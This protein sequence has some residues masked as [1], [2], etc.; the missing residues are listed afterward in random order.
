MKFDLNLALSYYTPQ[1]IAKYL[2]DVA[3]FDYDAAKA[4][5]YTDDEIARY[6]SET[7]QIEAKEAQPVPDILDKAKE[8]IKEAVSPL[9]QEPLWKQVLQAPKAAAETVLG[10]VTGMLAMLPAQVTYAAGKALE[11]LHQIFPE[12]KF[13]SAYTPGTAEQSKQQV[14]EALTYHPTTPAAQAALNLA[15]LPTEAMVEGA[16][17]V[18]GPI[19]RDV[20]ETTLSALPYK[21]VARMLPKTPSEAL[22][23]STKAEAVAEFTPI[24]RTIAEEGLPVSPSLIRPS[25]IT[26]LVEGILKQAPITRDIISRYQGKV[27]AWIDDNLREVS[28]QVLSPD[29]VQAMEGMI[30]EQYKEA[31]NMIQA[32]KIDLSSVVQALEK[33]DEQKALNKNG[34]AL[35]AELKLEPEVSLEK[36]DQLK[37]QFSVLKTDIRRAINNRF[38][39]ALEDYPGGTEAV[40][41]LRELDKGYRYQI[42]SRKIQKLIENSYDYEGRFLPDRFLSNYEAIKSQIKNQLPNIKETLD[43]VAEVAK[44]ARSDIEAWRQFEKQGGDLRALLKLGGAVAVISK[45]ELAM[46]LAGAALVARSMMHPKGVVRRLVGGR[47]PKTPAEAV[48]IFAPSPEEPPMEGILVDPEVFTQFRDQTRWP[49]YLTLYSPEELRQ[50]GAKTYIYGGKLL[51]GY[52]IMPD[53][54]LVNVFN[55]TKIPG[56]GQALI[57][58]AIKNGATKLDCIGDYLR[59]KYEAAGFEVYR[60]EPW[61][62]R[63]APEGWNYE[64]NGRPPIYY[65]RLKQKGGEAHEQGSRTATHQSAEGGMVE[66]GRM[67][68]AFGQERS[69]RPGMAR[70]SGSAE[71]SNYLASESKGQ[72]LGQEQSQHSSSGVGSGDNP[73]EKLPFEGLTPGTYEWMKVWRQ[74]KDNPEMQQKMLEYAKRLRG[75]A[76][77]VAVYLA[78]DQDEQEEAF[79]LFAG[80]LGGV[81]AVKAPKSKLVEAQELELKGLPKEGIWQRTGWIK[82]PENKWRFEIDDKSARILLN[83]DKINEILSAPNKK[84]KLEDLLYHEELYNQYPEL[85]ELPI[86]IDEK[87][88]AKTNAIF[89]P[90]AKDG[91][92]AIRIR[93][94]ALRDPS[95][96]LHEIQH[97]IQYKEGFGI[98]TSL[99]RVMTPAEQLEFWE[100]ERKKVDDAIVLK[101]IMLENNFDLA[102]AKKKFKE[103]FDEDP[104]GAEDYVV[105]MDLDT[106]NRWLDEINKKIKLA[107]PKRAFKEYHRAAGEAEAREVTKR[108]AYSPEEKRRIPPAWDEIPFEDLIVLLE[109]TGESSSILLNKPWQ[110]GTEKAPVMST[111]SKTKSS[112]D[113]FLAKQGDIMA[114]NRLVDKFFKPEKVK[115]L[116]EKYP[117]A[118][119]VPVQEIESQGT[120]KLPKALA[121]KMCDSFGFQLEPRIVS[122]TTAE[123]KSKGA[124]RRLISPKIFTGPVEP[125]RKYIL[126][127]DFLAQGGTIN[128]LKNYIEGL[129]GNVVGVV[130]LG[131]TKGGNVLAIRPETV[132]MLTKKFGRENLERFLREQNIAGEIEALTESQ[133]RA[134]LR[135]KDLDTLRD[136]ILQER[137]EGGGFSDLASFQVAFNKI[138]PTYPLPK[139]PSLALRR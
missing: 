125:G 90:K 59:E 32:E 52:A 67:P 100:K 6:L 28:N 8:R 102:R 39:D 78:L 128:E 38:Y 110:P 93:A 4:H 69:P 30:K 92:P 37:K 24:P 12:N 14:L 75:P 23:E 65:M 107:D 83:E 126:V 131:Q 10:G 40:E 43:R 71:G 118:I 87:L 72:G 35:L 108:L 9:E 137:S 82:G 73:L 134:I 113:Y 94:T 64:K 99:Q 80:V 104:T 101:V 46:P 26:K 33:F 62:D 13:L 95:T 47:L 121:I 1:E 49:E 60:Q 111:I 114:A 42:L 57:E 115:P 44:F 2:S 77:V 96:L 7:A 112:P 20:V 29:A 5:G 56:L 61:D 53:G 54:D 34:K 16:H 127:D 22:L 133:A 17:R 51:A 85:K 15:S 63:Y 79:P 139:Y 19:L 18:G 66:P 50:K 116:A 103:L 124:V 74:F 132:K 135:F 70:E 45:P 97:Y 68:E 89:I 123:H 120:N 76:G 117:D 129:G 122:I 55:E 138:N 109:P 81:Y 105:G 119:V 36:L 106:L 41:V 88:P 11:G 21:G 130:A 3:G 58:E 86:Y 84:V 27:V 25:R 91:S 136:R 31:F 48:D 98:G